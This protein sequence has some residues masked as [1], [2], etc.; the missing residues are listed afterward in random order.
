MMAAPPLD[1]GAVQVR[2][3]SWLPGVAT[4]PVGA[5]GTAKAGTTAFEA[6]EAALVPTELVAV[7]LKV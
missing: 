1:K 3:T 5:E 6:E 4:R 7:T 2:T